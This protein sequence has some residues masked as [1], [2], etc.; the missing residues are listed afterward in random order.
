MLRHRHIHRIQRLIRFL[1]VAS[2]SFTELVLGDVL[3]IYHYL[4]SVKATS[5]SPGNRDQS[6]HNAKAY[7]LGETGASCNTG[8]L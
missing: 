8:K 5:R 4:S 2:L 1:C 3:D 6:Y 7:M